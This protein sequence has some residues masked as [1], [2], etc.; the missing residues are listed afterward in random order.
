MRHSLNQRG[1]TLIE[2]LIALTL[3]AFLVGG[4]LQ[5]YIGSKR[6]YNTQQAATE[7]QEVGRFT[8]NALVSDIRMGGFFGCG[9]RTNMVNAL[10]SAANWAYDTDTPVLGYEGGASTFPGLFAGLAVANTDAIKIT[11]AIPDD[12][13]VIDTHATATGQM[14]LKTPHD[15]GQNEILVATDCLNSAVFQTTNA[16]AGSTIINHAS[17]GGTVGNCTQG[18]GAPLN[19]GTATGN[20]YQFNEDSFLMRFETNA[21]FI[22]IGANGRNSLFRVSLDNDGTLGVPIE[23]AEGVADMQLVYGV[24]N[25]GDGSV[26]AYL[27]ADAIALADWG[28]VMS[29]QINLLMESNIDRIADDPQ[30]YVFFD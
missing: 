22:G 10:N 8:L 2:L 18:L 24:D 3:G 20:P 26:D 1:Y 25:T 21:Y 23:M 14:S 27:L 5:L 11:R 16:G 13:Y 7:L 19:C 6:S 28:N 29:V 4:I 9:S 12:S 30:S 17:S 15:I